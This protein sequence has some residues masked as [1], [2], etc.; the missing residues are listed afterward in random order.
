[1][2][3]QYET[4]E[5]VKLIGE[6]PNLRFQTKYSDGVIWEVF[7]GNNNKGVLCTYGKGSGF[8]NKDFLSSDSNS[9]SRL[10]TEVDKSVDFITAIKALDGGKIIYVLHDGCYK[11]TFSPRGN[12]TDWGVAVKQQQG[13]PVDTELILYGKWYIED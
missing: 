1:M 10:W 5:V 2:D 8:E 7:G 11:E 4:W 9:M 6:N 12:Q 13:Y 3:K